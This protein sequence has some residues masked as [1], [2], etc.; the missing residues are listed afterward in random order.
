MDVQENG[1]G[2]TE[3]LSEYLPEGT[4]ENRDKPVNIVDRESNPANR[5]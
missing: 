2:L 5:N 1:R 4:E 3:V